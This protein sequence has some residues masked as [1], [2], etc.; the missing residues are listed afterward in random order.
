MDAA[1]IRAEIDALQRRET[2][3]RASI[4]KE[5]GDRGEGNSYTHTLRREIAELRTRDQEL[6]AELESLVRK[7][8][9]AIE[10]K[11][12]LRREAESLHA[13]QSR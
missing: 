3:F 1:A 12:S 2:E 5:F 4:D 13:S 6:S 11:D 9:A 7:L 10:R 8:E